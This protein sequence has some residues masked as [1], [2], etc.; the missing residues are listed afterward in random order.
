MVPRV[1]VRERS[2]TFR[3]FV[4]WLVGYGSNSFLAELPNTWV[5]NLSMAKGQ[6]RYGVLVRVPHV[7]KQALYLGA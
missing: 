2:G 1:L 3:E 6:T 7:E 5:S 4:L